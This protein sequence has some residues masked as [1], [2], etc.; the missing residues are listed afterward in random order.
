MKSVVNRR[1]EDKFEL[2]TSTE[3]GYFNLSCGCARAD[4]EILY[5]T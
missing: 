4:V 1:R 2:H 5:C 3:N